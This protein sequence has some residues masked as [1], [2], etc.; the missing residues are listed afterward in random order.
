[1]ASEDV[2]IYSQWGLRYI[3]RQ[4]ALLFEEA[5]WRFPEMDD[6]KALDVKIANDWAIAGSEN[7][8]YALID[9][10]RSELESL[11]PDS[12][13]DFSKWDIQGF[14]I[15][16][17]A[18]TDLY[19]K[20]TPGW[21]VKITIDDAQW[22]GT[23]SGGVVLSVRHLG[24]NDYEV[25][26]VGGNWVPFHGDDLSMDIIR[27]DDLKPPIVAITQSQSHGV[28][29]SETWICL[30][31]WRGIDWIPVIDNRYGDLSSIFTLGTVLNDSCFV[32]DGFVTNSSGE[33][34]PEIGYPTITAEKLVNQ[35][36]CDWRII[37]TFTWDG[38]KYTST[39][40]LYP[41]TI[42]KEPYDL[43]CTTLLLHQA[44]ILSNPE[45]LISIMQPYYD[46]WPA[47]NTP[48]IEDSH[49]YF[50]DRFGGS[51]F[52]RFRFHLGRLYALTGDLPMARTLFSELVAAPTAPMDQP[53]IQYAQQYL[54]QLPEVEKAEVLYVEAVKSGHLENTGDLDPDEVLENMSLRFFNDGEYLTVLTELEDILHSPGLEC[55]GSMDDGCA[56]LWYLL[57]LA[58]EHE[59][60]ETAAISAYL[61]IVRSFP[62][63]VYAQ[64]VSSRITKQSMK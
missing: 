43:G 7:A 10:L 24:D 5:L 54:D 52:D 27:H 44:A 48:L 63:G 59:G 56:G 9:V 38:T 39:Q 29:M 58:H 35:W 51:Y 36:L 8:T 12:Y 33:F 45:I 41:I 30:Y 4:V 46:S 40:E 50:G 26:K 11:P 34:A 42:H 13:P 16:Q 20:N 22:T 55:R 15:D 25:K 62:D 32:F 61:K 17:I 23:P 19:D 1:L 6:R 18:V 2:W 64:A 57:G 37:Y 28:G 31:Q 3:T 21:L 60:E 53:W 49:E 14:S 47:P